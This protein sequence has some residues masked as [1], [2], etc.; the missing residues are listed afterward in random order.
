VTR[1]PAIV[2]DSLPT[3]DTPPSRCRLQ[4][5]SSGEHDGRNNA[6][7]YAPRNQLGTPARP[8]RFLKSLVD[9]VPTKYDHPCA[10]QTRYRAHA[11][12]ENL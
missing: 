2:V 10:E 4:F 6:G 9:S 8:L 5:F 7:L 3:H 11:W 1:D 12:G